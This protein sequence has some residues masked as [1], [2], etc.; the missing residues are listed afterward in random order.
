MSENTQIQNTRDASIIYAL[1]ELE[2]HTV[3]AL[4]EVLNKLVQLIESQH[5]Q[6]LCHAYEEDAQYAAREQLPLDF[7]DDSDI[8]CS[9]TERLPF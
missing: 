3:D 2:P 4:V 1:S 6:S 8:A 5:H 7:I 9:D